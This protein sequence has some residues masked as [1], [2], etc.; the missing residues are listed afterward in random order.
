MAA[1]RTLRAAIEPKLLRGRLSAP[2][3][4]DWV[5]ATA[6]SGPGCVKT[7]TLFFKVV[8]HRA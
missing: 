7:R 6:A 5:S 4:Q 1:L 2:P 3:F 8:F